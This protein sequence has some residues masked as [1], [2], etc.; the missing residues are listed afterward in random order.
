MGGGAPSWMPGKKQIDKATKATRK[1]A[2][3]AFEELI[4]KPTKKIGKEGFDIIAGTTDEER[5]A[6]L[7]DK[8][9]PEPEV[10]PEVTPEVVPDETLLAST[11]RRRTKGKRSGAGGTLMEG[12]GVAYAKPSSKSPTGS[13]T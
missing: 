10:T 4:E 3:E 12:F 9:A 11:S 5:R 7:Y 8:Y 1:V 13:S 6:I 2:A